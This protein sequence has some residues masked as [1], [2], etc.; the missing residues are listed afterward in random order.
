MAPLVTDG[1]VVTV[2][3]MSPVAVGDLAIL[4]LRKGC[5]GWAGGCDAGL[6]HV[7][8]MAPEDI[9]VESLNPPELYA[10]PSGLLLGVHK[11]PWAARRSD[12]RLP[13]PEGPCYV[14]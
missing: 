3:L 1:A 7:V 12:E 8:V 9:V 6:K 2:D 14:P 13:S 10:L 4:F 11:C 5:G